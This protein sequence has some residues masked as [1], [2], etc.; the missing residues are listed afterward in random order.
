MAKQKTATETNKVVTTNKRA[1]FEYHFISELE[2]GIVLTGTEI[3]SV[4]AGKTN[5]NDA[6]CLFQK[7]ELYVRSMYIQEYELGTYSNH[8]AR[9]I[10]KLLI[11][12]SELTKF[13][14]RVKEKG[15]TIVP[16][17]LYINEK[18]LAKLSIAL[19]QGKK[20]YDKRE[21]IKEKDNKRDMDRLKKI[22]L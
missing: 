18:G 2:A 10:R 20:A 17:Q 14:R 19:A 11:N 9:R 4:R 5:L 22:K 15:F 7:G 6:Y 16:Y 1:K 12:R 13:E 21:T 3:K 8:D